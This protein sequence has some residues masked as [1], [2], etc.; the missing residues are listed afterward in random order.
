[1]TSRINTLRDRDPIVNPGSGAIVR[2]WDKAKVSGTGH[3]GFEVRVSAKARTSDNSM[4]NSNSY[5]LVPDGYLK[6]FYKALAN[7]PLVTKVQDAHYNIISL[8][9]YLNKE[10]NMDDFKLNLVK[11]TMEWPAGCKEGKEEFLAAIFGGK[12]NI[13]E[14]PKKRVRVIL[15]M[16]EINDAYDKPESIP[17]KLETN[18]GRYKNVNLVEVKEV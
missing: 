16:D 11:T 10:E 9:N 1:M 5:I 15:E 17:N 2:A 13:P 12:D 4:E 3:N 18:W 14:L 7:D 6:A 8:E